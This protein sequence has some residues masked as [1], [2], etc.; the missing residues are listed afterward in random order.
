MQS[1]LFL[2]SMNFSFSLQGNFLLVSFYNEILAIYERGSTVRW[3][4]DDD[5][6]I[7]S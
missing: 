6:L 7:N 5:I 1:F 3:L 2:F 4:K